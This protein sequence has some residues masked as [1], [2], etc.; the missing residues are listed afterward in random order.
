ME[1]KDTDKEVSRSEARRL[2]EIEEEAEKA[3]AVGQVLFD[4]ERGGPHEDEGVFFVELGVG[5]GDF[6]ELPEGL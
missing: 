3:I 4:D 6:V 1:G 2:R 5:V